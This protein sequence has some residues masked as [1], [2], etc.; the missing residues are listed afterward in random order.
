MPPYYGDIANSFSSTSESCLNLV[1]VFAYC[2]PPGHPI[3]V[4]SVLI[5][6]H[7]VALARHFQSV[8]GSLSAQNHRALKKKTG[9]SIYRRP[10]PF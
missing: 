9:T 2:S 5:Y 10:Q 6:A 7:V 4:R 3:L 8:M 1:P